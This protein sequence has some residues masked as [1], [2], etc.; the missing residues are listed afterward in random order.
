MNMPLLTWKR[1]LTNIEKSLHPTPLL[2]IEVQN[3]D[4]SLDMAVKSYL[5]NSQLLPTG[6]TEW[7]LLA[8][9]ECED[10]LEVKNYLE[11]LKKQFIKKTYFIPIRESMQNGGG[12][13]WPQTKSGTYR[14]R[15]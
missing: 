7:M 6:N 8:P 1:I 13:A 14:R 2:K 10:M 3:K 12:P 11:S 5:F 9:K 4:I 15:S